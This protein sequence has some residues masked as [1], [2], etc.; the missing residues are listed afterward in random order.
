MK[1][2]MIRKSDIRPTVVAVERVMRPLDG[3]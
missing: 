2:S 1:S 3:N